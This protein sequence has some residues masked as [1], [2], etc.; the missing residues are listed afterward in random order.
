MMRRLTTAIVTLVL[1]LV[2]SATVLAQGAQKE[3]VPVQPGA[4][5]E[6]IPAAPLVFIAYGFVWVALAVYV[7][8]IWRRVSNVERELLDLNRRLDSAKRS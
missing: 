8:F 3:F 1:P 5:Q 6:S 7:V 4:M 2:M